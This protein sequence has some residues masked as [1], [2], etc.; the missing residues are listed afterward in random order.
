MLLMGVVRFMR[1]RGVRRLYFVL[2][3]VAA[4]WGGGH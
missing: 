4:V 1:G 2:G 3:D